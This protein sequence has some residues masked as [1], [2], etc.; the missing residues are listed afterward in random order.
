[1]NV[2]F[3]VNVPEI[4]TYEWGP[5]HTGPEDFWFVNFH[6]WA[7]ELAPATQLT[8]MNDNGRIWRAKSEAA[9]VY[10]DERFPKLPRWDIIAIRLL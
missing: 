4:G 6:V 5:P 8:R 3:A 2:D 1:M 7:T 10:V 9:G